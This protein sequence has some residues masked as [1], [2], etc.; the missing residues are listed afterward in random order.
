[1]TLGAKSPHCVEDISFQQLPQR[2]VKQD[3][4][5]THSLRQTEVLRYE[6]QAIQRDKQNLCDSLV[7]YKKEKRKVTS[8]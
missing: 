3:L 8:S 6:G 4:T 7:Q 1:M 2:Q 5:Q